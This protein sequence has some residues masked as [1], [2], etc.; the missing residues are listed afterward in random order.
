MHVLLSSG[1]VIVAFLGNSNPL[2]V[3]NDRAYI[4]P[5]TLVR[6]SDGRIY[7]FPRKGFVP[8]ILLVPQSR[9]GDN[10]LGI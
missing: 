5:G 9:L 8:F 2:P 3:P 1:P 10:L 4:L 7:E 6:V